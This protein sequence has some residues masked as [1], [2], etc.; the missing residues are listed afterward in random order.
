MS[1]RNPEWQDN[2]LPVLRNDI[3][4]G[5]LSVITSCTISQIN[6]L[7]RKTW[8]NIWTRYNKKHNN[9]ITIVFL[10]LI[11]ISVEYIINLLFFGC[12]SFFGK[13]FQFLVEWELPLPL[14]NIITRFM[15]ILLFFNNKNSQRVDVIGINSL[16]IN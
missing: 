1:F 6:R 12:V 3:W 14:L 5:I 13:W 11:H 16:W 8:N 15:D 2:L 10:T 4:H 9:N 7:S